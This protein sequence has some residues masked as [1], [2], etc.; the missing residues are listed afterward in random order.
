MSTLGWILDKLENI[1]IPSSIYRESLEY[2]YVIIK[3]NL[4]LKT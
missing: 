4:I 3:E 2:I 1:K